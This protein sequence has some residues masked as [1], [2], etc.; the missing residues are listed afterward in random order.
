MQYIYL[1]AQGFIWIPEPK[2]NT[3]ANFCH[4]YHIITNSCEQYKFAFFLYWYLQVS[5]YFLLIYLFIL[6]L[7]K[8][9]LTQGERDIFFFL[10]WTKV[11]VP[12]L[13]VTFR[14]DYLQP[15]YLQRSSSNVLFGLDFHN[16]HRSLLSINWAT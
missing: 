15:H 13:R 4:L 2:A 7:N 11:S 12:F 10:R 16:F 14:W 6:L 1:L 5:F 9:L 8:F 3:A